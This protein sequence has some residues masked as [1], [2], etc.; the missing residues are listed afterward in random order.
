MLLCWGLGPPAVSFPGG[1]LS[2]H[3]PLMGPASSFRLV[4]AELVLE[5]R[6]IT[7]ELPYHPCAVAMGVGEGR[8]GQG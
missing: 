6:G 5:Q 7:T 4:R 2:S 1:M 3:Q 8:G